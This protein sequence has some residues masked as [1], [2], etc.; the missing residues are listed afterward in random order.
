MKTLRLAALAFLALIGAASVAHAQQVIAP[1]SGPRHVVSGTATTASTK[2]LGAT[3][4][5]VSLL[6]IDNESATIAIACSFGSETTASVNTA[7]SFTIPAGFTRVWQ[8]LYVPTDQ[9]N[10]ISAS[11]TADMTIE[12]EPNG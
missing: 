7:G 5:A 3:P 4:N 6:A 8:G 2:M 1:A 9:I 12:R 10:C 11:S